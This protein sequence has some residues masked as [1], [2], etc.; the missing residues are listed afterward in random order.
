[1][2][3]TVL[4]VLT[5]CLLT[6]CTAQKARALRNAGIQFKAEAIAAV[7]LM[8]E[9]VQREVAPPER[10]RVQA[11]DEFAQTV[12]AIVNSD[13]PDVYLN[14]STLEDAANPYA[15]K[16]GSAEADQARLVQVLTE[17]Y[18]VFEDAFE[19]LEQGFL[20][21]AAAVDA[22]GPTAKRLTAQLVVFAKHWQDN[23]PRFLQRRTT[24]IVA[25]E[26][27]ALDASLSEEDRGRRLAE[28]GEAWAALRAEETVA[29]RKIIE[30]CLKAATIGKQVQQMIDDF[31]KV[32]L[33][34]IQNF[35]AYALQTATTLTGADLSELTSYTDNL[36]TTLASD[37]AWSESIE[38]ALALASGREAELPAIGDPPI[39]ADVQP[40]DGTEE[41]E[42]T[43]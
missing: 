23:P 18:T 11:D 21:S 22:A 7:V 9:T 39:E 26:D 40:S 10:T 34:D 6:G 35:V 8:D 38:V 1:M 25:L 14:E 28:L 4:V 2:L 15:V 36:F 33:E 30:Q 20:F 42:P 19:D 24:I 5:V 12:L 16:P 37:P 32:S 17:Q 3:R 43:P 27:T 41:G 13:D 29:Q 31:D